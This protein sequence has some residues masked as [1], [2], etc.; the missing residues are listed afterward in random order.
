MTKLDDKKKKFLQENFIDRY[1]KERKNNNWQNY[2]NRSGDRFKIQEK[3]IPHLGNKMI[4][5]AIEDELNFN[6]NLQES[7]GIGINEESN[8]D[9]IVDSVLKEVKIVKPSEQ[10]RINEV[11]DFIKNNKHLNI[12]D[13][14][15]L[16]IGFRVP[17]IQNYFKNSLSCN[18]AMGVDINSFN[19]EV[20]KSLGYNVETYNLMC[21]MSIQEKFNRSFDLV[22][23][24]H[25]L[26]HVQNPFKALQ[27]I[28]NGLKV[29]GILHVEVPIEPGLPRLEYGHLISFE[30][31]ELFKLLEGVGLSVKTGSNKTH[32]GGPWIERY[33][34][35]KEV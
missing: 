31:K 1:V 32:E 30:P 13:F 6:L 26:E 8:I 12:S 5:I 24:Y 2:R 18:F 3:F 33:I 11:V 7:R 20:C 15:F 27:N 28:Y 17:T 10:L 35:V 19:V 34:A 4:Y 16:E 21:D 9:N 23:C 22:S 14:D 25:V 29:G